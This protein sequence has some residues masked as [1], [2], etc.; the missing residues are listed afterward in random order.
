VVEAIGR[1]LY[2][3]LAAFVLFVVAMALTGDG[4]IDR[5]WLG[6]LIAMGFVG[7]VPVL[8]D[9][10]SARRGATGLRWHGWLLALCLLASFGGIF[11]AAVDRGRMAH[12]LFR[13]GWPLFLLL[14]VGYE[15]ALLYWAFRRPR[16][17]WRWQW[18]GVALGVVLF[19]LLF[20]GC[21][22]MAARRAAMRERKMERQV[23][24]GQGR[25]LFVADRGIRATVEGPSTR[26]S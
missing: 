26:T 20:L 24:A 19:L 6:I 16:R 23:P 17:R 4:K 18:L 15:I 25:A 9:W 11:L 13:A 5:G 7:L 14:F 21:M 1:G 8:W 10:L 22:G 3:A 12:H 2:G